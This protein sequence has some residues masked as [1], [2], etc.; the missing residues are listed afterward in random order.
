MNDTRGSVT[1]RTVT[2]PRHLGQAWAKAE[3]LK[4]TLASE[5]LVDAID[6]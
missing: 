6:A 5:A 2:K 4:A 1:S 3:A